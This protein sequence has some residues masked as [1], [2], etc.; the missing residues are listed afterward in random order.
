MTDKDTAAMRQ[1]LTDVLAVH[2]AEINGQFNLIKQE[3]HFIK[4]QTT[5]TNGRV[6]R[7]D[8]LFHKMELIEKDHFLKCPNTERIS[9][10][11][12]DR[13]G[14]KSI[15]SFVVKVGMFVAAVTG[16][17]IAIIELIIK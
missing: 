12:D 9:T 5:K 14:K 3:L 8:E 7:H 16:I 6:T 17:V 10:L 1:I 13:T 15:E 11:E 4:D 2:T